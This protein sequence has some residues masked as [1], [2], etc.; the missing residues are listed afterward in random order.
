MLNVPNVLTLVR[1]LTIPAFLILLT[2]G[3][4]GM[5][6]AVFVAGGITDALDG[7]IARLTNTKTELGAILDPLAD[8]LLL[9]SSF[10]VLALMDLVPNWLTVLVLF[11][12]VFLLVGYFFLFVFTGEWIE[13]RPSVVG[14]VT[15]FFQLASVTIVL[16]SVS[17]PEAIPPPARLMLFVGAATFTALSGLQY[18]ARGLRWLSVRD[19]DG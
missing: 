4:P 2:N 9:L 11:R 19:S 16:V 14:K 8:K 6:L 1:I 13:V 18:M 12:D 7:A 5:A 3:R 15:T 17:W 10:C